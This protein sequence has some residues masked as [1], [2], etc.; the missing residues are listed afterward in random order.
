MLV[1][2][3][4]LPAVARS[5]AVVPAKAL[6]MTADNLQSAD[7]R[8]RDLA[9]QRGGPG[10]TM[11]GDTVRYRLTFTNLQRDSVH[12]VQFNDLLPGGLQY[13]AG[14]GRADRGDVA[15]EFSIDGGKSY[16]RE[17][18]V[19]ENVDGRTVRRPAPASR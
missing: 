19:E 7:Q 6:V 9:V 8:H 14:S 3:T 1:T 15:I 5:Q 13:V 16:S 17:P 18:M 12:N 2:A 11:P 4:L 10:P